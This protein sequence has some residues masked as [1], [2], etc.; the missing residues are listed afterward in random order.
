M[1][2]T[3]W[4]S[5]RV[6]FLGSGVVVGHHCSVQRDIRFESRSLALHELVRDGDP[7]SVVFSDVV[8]LLEVVCVDGQLFM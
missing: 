2:D 6:T 1:F 7:R 3:T 4:A 5:R 8:N